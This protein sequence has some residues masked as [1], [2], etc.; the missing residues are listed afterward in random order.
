MG[1]KAVD[2]QRQLREA[3]QSQHLK[4]EEKIHELQV[5]VLELKAEYASEK[6]TC[7]RRQREIKAA[8]GELQALSQGQQTLRSELRRAARPA[9]VLPYFASTL[10][11][12]SG[13]ADVDFTPQI[14][15]DAVERMQARVS[16]ARSL[17]RA[18]PQAFSCANSLSSDK[19]RDHIA[20][21]EDARAQYLSS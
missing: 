19:V 8:L 7:N 18:L 13:L 16:M 12:V 1:K 14:C 17:Q 20:Y 3:E 5:E 11:G 10:R 9:P 2:I 21:L 6:Q 4:A 15:Q